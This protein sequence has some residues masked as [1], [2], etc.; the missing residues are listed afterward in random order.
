LARLVEEGEAVLMDLR[1]F[2]ATNAGCIYELRHLMENVPFDRWLLIVDA[3]TDEPFF[4]RTLKEAWER[5]SPGSPNYLRSFDEVTVHRFQS[6]TTALRP[7]LRRLCEAS[8]KS[9]E[10]CPSG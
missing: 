1:S 4:R 10:R 9:R 8:M 5:L 6:G 7:I 3:T 2:S